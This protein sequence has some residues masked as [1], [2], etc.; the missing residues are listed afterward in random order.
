M[1]ETFLVLFAS[2]P[3]TKML[4]KNKVWRHRLQWG[5]KTQPWDPVSFHRCFSA[6]P[7]L[8]P[9]GLVVASP[10]L[11]FPETGES[12]T[13]PP[14]SHWNIEAVLLLMG[15]CHSKEHV[16][17]CAQFGCQVKDKMRWYM[18]FQPLASVAMDTRFCHRGKNIYLLIKLCSF[19]FSTF[20]DWQEKNCYLWNQENWIN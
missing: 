8:P 19:L 15:P 7:L 3:G 17:V 5:K 12:E 13:E 14:E 6:P 9:S 16:P 10:T 4:E 20:S 11:T 2:A 18:L 1:K